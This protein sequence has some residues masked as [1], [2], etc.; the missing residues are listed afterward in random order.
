MPDLGVQGCTWFGSATNSRDRNSLPISAAI[1]GSE[2]ANQMLSDL[3]TGRETVDSIAFW[4]TELRV[5]GHADLAAEVSA[6]LPK[7][8]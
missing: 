4:V 7:L 6:R 3:H 8:N 1:V 2:V 5:E